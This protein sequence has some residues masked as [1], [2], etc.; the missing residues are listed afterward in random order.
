M[1]SKILAIVLLAILQAIVPANA[2][3]TVTVKVALSE[4]LP[5]ASYAVNG[6]P[7]GLLK[8]MLVELFRHVPG[9]RLEFRTYPWARAQRLVESG[10]MD[11]FVTF[12]SASRKAYAAFS[13]HAIYTLDYG[14]L[15]FDSRSSK[16]AKLETARSFEDLRGLT[17]ISQE[18]VSWEDENVPAYIK[19]YMVNTPRSMWHMIFQRK[20]GD[21]FIM[22]VEHAIYIANRYG[23]RDQLRMKKVDFIPN[24]LVEF[25]VGLRKNHPQQA[26]L[27]HA[28]DAAMVHPEFVAK[29]KAIE[30]KYRELA[31]AV[32]TTDASG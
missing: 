31:K 8:D 7:S 1:G 16:A 29:R 19:R 5:P 11:M 15:V 25:H 21:F 26:A 6:E 17:F 30:R 12:P 18:G 10:Q 9:Y 24:S 13:P 3:S 2:Q 32:P 4:A 22:S 20:A 28:I 27:L 23:Y 14:N